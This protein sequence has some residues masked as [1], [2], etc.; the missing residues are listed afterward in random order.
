MKI[1]VD[2]N[3]LKLFCSTFGELMY[4]YH[5]DVESNSYENNLH[6]TDNDIKYFDIESNLV[7][8][9]EVY[10]IVKKNYSFLN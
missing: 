2:F 10:K 8:D 1:S 5:F 6:L 7:K 3:D 9:Y 4:Y